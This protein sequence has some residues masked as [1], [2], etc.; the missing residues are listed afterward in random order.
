MDPKEQNA[1]PTATP[2]HAAPMPQ[3]EV[4]LRQL[5]NEYGRPAIYGLILALVLYMGITLYRYQSARSAAE[6]M[7]LLSSAQSP[8]QLQTVVADYARTPSAPVALLA[9]ARDDYQAARYTDARKRYEAFAQAYPR[10][11]M[12]AFAQLGV[13]L[14]DEALGADAAALAAY[15][16]LAVEQAAREMIG[17][18]ALFG[19]AR[20]LDRAG[21]TDEARAIYE[22]FV[23]GHAGSPWLPVAEAALEALKLGPGLTRVAPA[24]APALAV[25]PAAPLLPAPAAPAVPQAPALT[26]Q[27]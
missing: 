8:E 23:A 6:A 22:E 5:M 21:K 19:K 17:P 13:A 12:A 15:T 10:H 9:L 26:P 14:C 11:A 4:D 3:D 16:K 20:L 25:P 27:P 2:H 18:Q 7:A 1:V 24:P